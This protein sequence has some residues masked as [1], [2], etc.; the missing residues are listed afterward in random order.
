M[1][2]HTWVSDEPPYDLWIK[3]TS[4]WSRQYLPLETLGNEIFCIIS[5][6]TKYH[7]SN[8]VI[9]RSIKLLH[10]LECAEKGRITSSYTIQLGKSE[11]DSVRF[12]TLGLDGL[13]TTLCHWNASIAIHDIYTLSIFVGMDYPEESPVIKFIGKTIFGWKVELECVDEDGT[14]MVDKM[15]IFKWNRNQTLANVL[16]A[17]VSILIPYDQTEAFHYDNPEKRETVINKWRQR[18]T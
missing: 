3:V 5:R 16:G 13:D 9:P 4:F 10:E 15:K 2:Q 17:L 11:Y 6:Y 8:Y 14:V 1:K 18:H 7:P 12:A